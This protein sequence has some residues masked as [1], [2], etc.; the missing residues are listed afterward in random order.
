MD[1]TDIDDFVKGLEAVF[2]GKA[3]ILNRMRL[4]CTFY[5]NERKEIGSADDGQKSSTATV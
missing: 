5:D 3:T 4:S 1:T 2:Q